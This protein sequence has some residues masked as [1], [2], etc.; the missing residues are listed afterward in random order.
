[1]LPIARWIGYGGETNFHGSVLE[2][3]TWAAGLL[4]HTSDITVFATTH[5][6]ANHPVVVAK[7]LATIDVH[8]PPKWRVN[9]ALSATPEFA[10]A[11]R[12]KATAKLAPANA[13]VVW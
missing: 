11:F 6:A 4:A 7:Q 5:T 12:C 13:C 10:K 1:M 3:I 2:T 8:S 9:G